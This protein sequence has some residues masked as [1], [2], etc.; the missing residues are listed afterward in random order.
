MNF[1]T[2]IRRYFKRDISYMLFNVFSVM[3]LVSVVLM[4]FDILGVQ[5]PFLNELSHDINILMGFF[6]VV[7]IIGITLLEFI[8]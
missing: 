8:F 4:A 2:R 5:N 7:S 1:E 3:I 6:M